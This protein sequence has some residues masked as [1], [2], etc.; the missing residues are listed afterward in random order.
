MSVFVLHMLGFPAA[1]YW[2]SFYQFH[3]YIHQC[4]VLQLI[5]QVVFRLL[6]LYGV[7]V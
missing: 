1:H 5:E 6:V 3:N 4:L 2:M 7:S